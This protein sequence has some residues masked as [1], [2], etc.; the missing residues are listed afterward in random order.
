MRS[1]TARG[2]E[3]T[4]RAEAWAL[5]INIRVLKLNSTTAT[6]MTLTYPGTPPI[7]LEESLGTSN[8][9]G[10]DDQGLR[11]ITITHYVCQYG[12]AGHYN[13]IIQ[14]AVD[15]EESPNP[16][17][18]T[19]WKDDEDVM[20]IVTTSTMDAEESESLDQKHRRWTTERAA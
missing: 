19:H 11:T 5:R 13:P 9:L 10:S 15:D 20:P 18:N 1:E 8:S 4:I 3:V 7:D 2:D 16:V 17:S 12:G 14:R 6:I